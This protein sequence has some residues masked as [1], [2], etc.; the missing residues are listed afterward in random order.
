MYIS[1]GYIHV[2][3]HALL[4]TPHHTSPT[5]YQLVRVQHV[6]PHEMRAATERRAA[7]CR[8]NGGDFAFLRV[9]VVACELS[10]E[11]GHGLQGCCCDDNVQTHDDPS[12]TGIYLFDVLNL[13]PRAA[14][15]RHM[16]AAH[17]RHAHLHARQTGVIK[18]PFTT[19]PRSRSSARAVR[20]R[21]TITC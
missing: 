4:R 15:H 10:L 7:R 20:L 14:A 8:C 19:L 11:H 13:A 21:H 12:T 3:T 2:C 9:F 16:P 5:S 6:R 18:T 17:M 1:M